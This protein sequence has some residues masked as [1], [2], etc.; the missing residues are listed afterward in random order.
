MC[1]LVYDFASVQH[2]AIMFEVC[3]RERDDEMFYLQDKVLGDILLTNS[4]VTK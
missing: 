4:P 1:L 2:R 3:V